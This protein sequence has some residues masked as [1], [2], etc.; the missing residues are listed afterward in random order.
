MKLTA[1]ETRRFIA[2]L[3][4]QR[5][6]QRRCLR[7]LRQDLRALKQAAVLE[8]LVAFESSVDRRQAAFLGL[9]ALNA[10]VDKSV[11]EA[12]RTKAVIVLSRDAGVGYGSAFEFLDAEKGITKV[13]TTLDETRP[14][15]KSIATSS[16]IKIVRDSGDEAGAAKLEDDTWRLSAAYYALESL[17]RQSEAVIAA[18]WAIV[19]GQGLHFWQGRQRWFRYVGDELSEEYDCVKG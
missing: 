16:Q 7:Q 14:L 11:G 13:I 8:Q 5:A 6:T 3:N 9:M 1:G 17:S 15:L 12:L 10:Q 2:E 4:R 19:H 18:Q